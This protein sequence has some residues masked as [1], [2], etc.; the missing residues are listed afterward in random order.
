MCR[1]AP[2]FLRG[3]N[4]T[5][6]RWRG[7]L[8]PHSEWGAD[9]GSG[10]PPSALPCQCQ[11]PP[12]FCL[13]SSGKNVQRR[14]SPLSPSSQSIGTALERMGTTEGVDRGA[15]WLPIVSQVSKGLSPS[16]APPPSPLWVFQFILSW[17]CFS[18]IKHRLKRSAGKSWYF[19]LFALALK[20]RPFRGHSEFER[21]LE[22]NV[23]TGEHFSRW[24]CI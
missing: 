15:I 4:C 10:F 21:M 19:C 24:I 7:L 18:Q 20:F 11:L 5:P 16:G 8:T 17:H 22:W 1:P 3:R 13:M 23:R 6:E 14:R 9:T 12:T 2:L